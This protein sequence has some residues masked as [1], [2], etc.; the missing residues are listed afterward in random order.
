M[1][2]FMISTFDL[3]LLGSLVS[4]GGLVFLFWPPVGMRLKRGAYTKGHRQALT[5]A[6]ARWLT[7]GPLCLFF[8][9][10][11]G[12]DSGYLFGPWRNVLFHVAFLCTCWTATVLRIGRTAETASSVIGQ[13]AP[14]KAPSTHSLAES[15]IRT[16]LKDFAN[17]KRTAEQVSI[18]A[19]CSTTSLGSH[20]R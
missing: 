15:V 7:V 12:A 1:E 16:S 3:P 17:Q 10:T 19:G 2:R 13:P 4:A 14:A 20:S 5:M 6:A 18:R 11:H 8:A 9:H